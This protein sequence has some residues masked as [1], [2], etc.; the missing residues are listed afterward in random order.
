MMEK[1][2]FAISHTFSLSRLHAPSRSPC[3]FRMMK[4]KLLCGKNAVL[5]ILL[6]SFQYCVQWNL[7]F[8]SWM[9]I[10]FYGTFST[11]PQFS[12]K[13][14]KIYHNQYKVI[15]STC[16]IFVK[17]LNSNDKIKFLS[18]CQLVCRRVIHFSIDFH[19]CGNLNFG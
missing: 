14:K 11:M 15:A 17:R 7:Y 10:N 3:E 19:R 18:A 5:S 12:F 8:G 16:F 6:R 2:A 1:D 4:F 9:M 13:Q